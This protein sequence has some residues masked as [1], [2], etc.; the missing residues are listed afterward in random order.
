M[1]HKVQLAAPACDSLEET[2]G[3]GKRRGGAVS[4]SGQG[5]PRIAAERVRAGRTGRE[6]WERVGE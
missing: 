5:S 3:A 6:R 2:D 1:L 4:C